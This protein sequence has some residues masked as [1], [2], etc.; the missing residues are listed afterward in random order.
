M[1]PP[2]LIHCQIPRTCRVGLCGWCCGSPATRTG[3]GARYN[4]KSLKSGSFLIFFDALCSV[5]FGFLKELP[6]RVPKGFLAELPRAL[7]PALKWLAQKAGTCGRLASKI[8]RSH[9]GR[10]VLWSI[11]AEYLPKRSDHFGRT[12]LCCST[13]CLYTL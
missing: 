9:C 8:F 4:S 11:C 6:E 3:R 10:E 5:C 12:M 1:D 7:R 2:I 13:R